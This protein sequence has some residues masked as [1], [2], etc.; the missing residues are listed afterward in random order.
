MIAAAVPMPETATVAPPTAADFAAPSGAEPVTGTT[1]A[2]TAPATAAPAVTE[3]APAVPAASPAATS[4]V[5]LASIDQQ[6]ADKIHE[7]LGAKAD[8]NLDRRYKS[9][10]E[11]YYAARNYAPLWSENG[12]ENSRAKDAGAYLA[13]VDAD[14]LDAGDYPIPSF[15]TA[16]PGALAE[17]E[18]KFTAT[19]LTFARHAQLGRVHYSRISKDIFYDQAAPEPAA[20]LAKLADAKNVG[21]ALDSFNPPQEGYKALKAKLAEARGHAGAGGP[22]H[23]ATG[24]VLKVGM[25]D[26]RATV[27]RERLGVTA[28]SDSTTYDKA[29]ADAVKTF[30]R[31]RDLPATGILTNAVVDALNGP[32]RDR[33]ADIIIANMERWRWLPRD[34]GKAYVMVNIPD[35]TLKVVNHG[36]M[37]WTTRIVTG[38][39]GEKGDPAAHG[40][41]EIH[42]RQPDLERAALHHQQ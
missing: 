29:L 7:L 39:P 31:Q 10:I 30:Q 19:V 26:P 42:H 3:T 9:A 35:Y 37:V 40:D 23:I 15:A 5:A 14:G 32:R 38:K 18:L 28:G 22:P 6:V 13:G 4:A 36:E 27:L 24:A 1:P 20:V 16:D 8:H 12:A 17:A 21:A 41:D 25:A 33:D 2:Q 34:L 11:T